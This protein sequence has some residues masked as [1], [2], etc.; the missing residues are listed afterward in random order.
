MSKVIVDEIQTDTADGNVRIIPN[1][2]GKLEIKGAGGDDAMIRLNCSAQTHG[3]K[4]KSPNHIAGQSYT[5]IL[6][7]NDIQAGKFLRVKS[8]TG[9][10]VTQ[11]VGQLE[12]ADA[13]G[14][15]FEFVQK[16]EITSGNT[17]A[18]L[19]FTN[20]DNDAAYRLVAKQVIQTASSGLVNLQFKDTSNNL[21]TGKLNYVRR[22]GS[23]QQQFTGEDSFLGAGLSTN[24][25]KIAF[26]LEFFTKPSQAW[27]YFQSWCTGGDL[28][29]M[30][31]AGSLNDTTTQI[32]GV[33]IND[34]NNGT[35]DA[36][37]QLLLYKY[38]ES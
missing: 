36:G 29:R 27:F 21:I 20:L 2:T 1:G 17:A 23:S 22:Y 19:D 24:V 10:P 35:L 13:G 25:K 31:A 30:A 3:V 38:K 11:A 7:D 33:R 8:V 12:Y 26:I 5:M 9:T 15:G 37:T 34:Y 4:I 16:G 28:E 18:F 6:P 32:G 14:G